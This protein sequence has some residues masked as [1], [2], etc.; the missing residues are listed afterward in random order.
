MVRYRRNFVYGGTFFFTVTVADRRSS[1]LVEHAAAL[2]NAFRVAR[3][4]RPFTIDAI[5]VLPD[6]LHTIMTLPQNDAD[7]SGRW[8]QIKSLFTQEVVARGFTAERNRRGEYALWQR[9]F[10]E[11]T[12][13]DDSDLSRHVDYIHYNPVKHGLVSR[14]SDWRYSSFHRYV[15]QGLLPPDWGGDV[16]EI[17][18]SFGERIG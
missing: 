10:W 3:A 8:R 16:H 11:H 5:V 1:V 9:R 2:R 15:Q 17:G 12:I 4:K 18:V 6:H 7:F 14:V 13:R